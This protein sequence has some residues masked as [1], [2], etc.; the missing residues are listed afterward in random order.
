MFRSVWK[1]VTELAQTA[2]DLVHR[3][4]LPTATDLFRNVTLVDV[5]KIV[6]K[7]LRNASPIVATVTDFVLEI[8]VLIDQKC[9]ILQVPLTAEQRS[10]LEGGAMVVLGTPDGREVPVALNAEPQ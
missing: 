8:V 3:R 6:V 4:V 2:Y 5:G 10:A 1:A 7:V 9:Q